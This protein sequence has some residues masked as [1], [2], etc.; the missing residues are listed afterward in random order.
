MVFL[1]DAAMMT[2][3]RKISGRSPKE[4]KSMKKE[5]LD[6]PITTKDFDDALSR[7]KKSVSETDVKRYENWLKQFGSE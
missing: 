6:V 4:I 1:R 5:D 7:C 2:M 3:R